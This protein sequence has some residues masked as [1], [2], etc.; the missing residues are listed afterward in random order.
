VVEPVGHGAQTGFEV[1]QALAVGELGEDHAQEL[2]PAAKPTDAEVA[3][4]T[5]DASTEVVVWGVLQ[6]LR[7]DRASLVHRALLGRGS[8]TGSVQ[9]ESSSNRVRS[10]AHASALAAMHY[11][12]GRLNEPDSSELSSKALM[13]GSDV[14]GIAYVRA[15]DTPSESY[16]RDLITYVYESELVAPLGLC[17]RNKSNIAARN[18]LVTSRIEKVADVRFYDS[19]EEPTKPTKH[20]Y[21]ATLAGIRPL[22]D[23]FQ[24]KPRPRVTNFPT[25]WELTIP[26][27]TVLPKATVWSTDVIYVG[28]ERS[29][30]L[31]MPIQVYAENLSNPVSLELTVVVSVEQRPM[32]RA[33]LDN[34]SDD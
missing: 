19:S 14:L 31:V 21:L 29:T 12:R 30:D 18:V 32:T 27:G 34:G 22:S 28:S 20:H 17:I 13:P 24:Q 33:D 26:F 1:A 3:A 6:Q 16:Y 11:R 2:I 4:V 5:F 7:E 15:F 23:H 9:R 8:A 10:D 25:H